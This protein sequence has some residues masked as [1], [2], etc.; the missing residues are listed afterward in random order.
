MVHF[1][2]DDF[3]NVTSVL[4]DDA[5][6]HHREACVTYEPSGTYPWATRNAEGHTSYHVFDAGLGVEL[7]MRDPNALVTTWEYDNAGRVISTKAP[8]GAISNHTYDH[9]Q[10]FTQE[11][12]PDGGVLT[13]RTLL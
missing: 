8:W 12:N 1:L 6:G 11:S 13:K 4:A 10:V 9:D 5:F 7:S 3:G 2:R